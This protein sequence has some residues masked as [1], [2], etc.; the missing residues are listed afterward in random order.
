M[1]IKKLVTD[2]VYRTFI[3]FIITMILALLFRIFGI[4]TPN[5]YVITNGVIAMT[6]LIWTRITDV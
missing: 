6:Y 1:K 5:W 3:I 4:L 2:K